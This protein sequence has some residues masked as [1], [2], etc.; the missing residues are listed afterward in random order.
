MSTPVTP[1]D[2]FQ[3]IL[4][5]ARLQ[6][7]LSDEL[8]AADLRLKVAENLRFDTTCSPGQPGQENLWIPKFSY[9]K[10]FALLWPSSSSLDSSEAQ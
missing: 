7:E 9:T 2:Y 5:S 8:T 4:A 10:F 6:N 1:A 3:P